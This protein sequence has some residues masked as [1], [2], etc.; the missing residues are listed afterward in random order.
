MFPKFVSRI[1]KKKPY[2]GKEHLLMNIKFSELFKHTRRSLPLFLVHIKLTIIVEY[3]NL[4]FMHVQNR[5]YIK[6]EMKH[7]IDS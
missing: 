5:I 2:L 3:V 4:K 7:E 6:F 1:K